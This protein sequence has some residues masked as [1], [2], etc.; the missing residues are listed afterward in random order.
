MRLIS[1]SL[2]LFLAGILLGQEFRGT[3]LGQVT[4][5]TGAVV[6]DA[7]ITITNTQ[8][9][10]AANTKSNSD[11]NYQAP[12]LLPGTY[13]V[14]A[15]RTGFKK[16][17]QP[18][19]QV[20]AAT[21]VTVNLVLELG[22]NSQ[23]VTVKSEAPLLETASSDLGQNVPSNY[24]ADVPESFYRNAA[25]FARLAPGVTG[26]SMGTYTSDNQTAISISG[27]GGIQ[28]GNEWI[29]D[30]VPDTVPLS[31]GSV[32]FVPTV[33]SV[34]EMRVNTTMFDAEYGHSNGGAVT[35]ATKSGTNDLHG[36]AYLFK[37]W[38]LLNANTWQNDKNGVPKPGVNYHQWGYYLGG[39]VYIPKVYNGKNKTF[40]STWLESDFDVRDLSEEARVPTALERQGNFSQTIEKVG[41]RPVTIYNPFS[42]VVTNGKATRQP[43]QNNTIPVTMQNPI[44]VAIL[45]AF[46]LP[47]LP[48]AAQIGGNNWYEDANYFVGQR[49]VAGRVDQYFGDRDKMFVRYSRLTRDQYPDVLFPG[50]NSVN[51][52]GANLDTYLQWRTSVALNDTYT[53]SPTLVGS[54]SYG[55]ARRVNNDSYGGYGLD[56]SKFGVPSIITDNQTIKGYPEFNLGENIPD[57]GSRINVIANNTHAFLGTFEKVAGKHT[58]KFGADFRIVQYNT[59]SQTTAAA[60]SFTFSSVF[61]QSDPFT[62]TT[63]NTSGTAMAS[64]LLGV[65]ASGSF[66]YTSPLSLQSDYTGLFIQDGWK[67]T[68]KLTLNFGVR[69][70]LE[71]PYNERYN[72]V[73]W[74]FNYTAPF[75]IQAP[76]LNL[77]GGPE[78]VAANGYSR[79]EG[80]LD[81]NNFGPRFGFAYQL[82][83]NTVLRGGYGLFYSSQLDDTS[84]LGSFPTFSPSTTYVG[85]VDNGATPYTTISN[86][87]PNGLQPVLGSSLGVASNAGNAITM[88]NPYRVSPYNQQW[89]FS[90]QQQ[91]PS[92]VLIEAAY[93]GMLSVKELE[94]YNLNDLQAQY[95]ALGSAQ[96]ASVKNPFF[97]RFPSNSTL[98]ASSTIT[99]RQLWLQYPQY[100]SVT[101]DGMN[102]GVTTYNALQ[103]KVQKR[104]TRGLSVIGAYTFSKEMHNN[105]T[106]LVNALHYRSISSI[107]QPQLIRIAVVYDLPFHFAGAGLARHIL[108]EAAGDWEV[109]GE[110]SLDSG[111]PLSI[112]Q[113]NGRPLV[114]AD[115]EQSGPV[116]QR[117]GDRVVNGVAQNPY[118]NIN[119]FQALPSQYILSSQVPYI[120]QLR[121]PVQAYV[122]ASLFKNFAIRERLHAELRLEAYNATNHPYFNAPGTNMSSAATFGVIT[123]A[124]NSRSMQA[125]LKIVF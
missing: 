94:S 114:I 98:G 86:P 2:F 60:G 8:T 88:L 13:T 46:P 14:V 1:V 102:T 92:S 80:N 23:T 4:D 37:R 5:P 7:A 91:L 57:I 100:T 73:A 97:G 74:G 15:D 33:D 93:V 79:R 70:E 3:I 122:N 67:A 29:I 28:G 65:A 99:Q 117:L 17:E 36:T 109:T 108:R 121:A 77:V 72:R 96:N 61:T 110:W 85:T 30:G 66:G 11:G 119:A 62:N 71:T 25:N 112:T 124:S 107:D 41:T 82:F 84:D 90:V 118:F 27:G 32:V 48:A 50:I 115:P 22:S 101:L 113:A 87:F 9:G 40:F 58:L 31:T 78:F 76:G 95:L 43:F 123:G 19:V 81:A 106:S 104:M 24:V 6:P 120:S 89:Q 125:G 34:Q 20:S 12:F 105:L 54:F 44:G 103:T 10:V 68:P 16:A 21:S 56:P 47:N 49:E 26:Q 83:H 53:F 45:N 42:T 69:Y 52:S 63:A 35:I 64:A 55:F 51:G 59:A 18:N 38:A 39:P 75:P 111:L 116:D